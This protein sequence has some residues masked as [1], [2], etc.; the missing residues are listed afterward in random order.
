METAMHRVIKLFR[1]WLLPTAMRRAEAKRRLDQVCQANGCSRS[2]SKRI[3]AQYFG[4]D[5]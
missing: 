1:F 5:R 3:S 4:V 2:Q